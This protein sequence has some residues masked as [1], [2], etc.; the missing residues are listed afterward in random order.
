MSDRTTPRGS[1]TTHLTA[2][3]NA[4][5]HSFIACCWFRLIC[6]TFHFQCSPQSDH[7][8]FEFRLLCQTDSSR[9]PDI[10]ADEGSR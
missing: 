2:P 9:L 8:D 3:N 6:I 5:S 4:Q 7:S 1:D 10:S